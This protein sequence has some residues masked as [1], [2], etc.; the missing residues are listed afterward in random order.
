MSMRSSAWPGWSYPTDLWYESWV[1]A[2][3]SVP[4]ELAITRHK[5]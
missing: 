1:Q 5:Y 3:Y 4:N 2:I